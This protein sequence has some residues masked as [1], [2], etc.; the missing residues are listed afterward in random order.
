MRA[1]TLSIVWPRIS[2]L[3]RSG[4]AAL[5]LVV[6]LHDRVMRLVAVVLIAQCLLLLDLA[7][8]VIAGILPLVRRQ[9]SGRRSG[10]AIPLIP[11]LPL[12]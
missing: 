9:G 11:P 4:L 8:I 12:L 2:V 1:G 6:L 10:L 5:R 7:G 3:R